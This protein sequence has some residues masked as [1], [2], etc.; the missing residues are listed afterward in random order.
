MSRVKTIL[1]VI[2]TNPYTFISRG[3]SKSSPFDEE[4]NEPLF[5]IDSIV[6]LTNGKFPLD[7]YQ[8]LYPMSN[9]VHIIG[10]KEVGIDGF[11]YDCKDLQFGKS[12]K[13]N[14]ID[15]SNDKLGGSR[16]RRNNRRSNRRSRNNRRNNRRNRTRRV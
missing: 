6:K 5:P 10:N 14:V 9:K 16:R 1:E 11:A 7:N 3:L 15:L 2:N 4:G 12:C 13:I 8:D